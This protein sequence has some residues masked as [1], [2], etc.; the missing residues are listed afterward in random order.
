MLDTF[1]KDY[2]DIAKTELTGNSSYEDVYKHLK[3]YIKEAHIGLCKSIILMISE[4]TKDENT[5][6]GRFEQF[7]CYLLNPGYN[8]HDEYFLYLK[9][10]V[11]FDEQL[12]ID[13]EY[14]ETFCKNFVLTGG[15]DDVDDAD[16]NNWLQNIDKARMSRIIKLFRE[17]PINGAIPDLLKRIDENLQAVSGVPEAVVQEPLRSQVAAHGGERANLVPS[18]ACGLVVTSAAAI[19]S[20][21]KNI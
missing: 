3:I 11:L 4:L 16:H 9:N 10:D 19:V 12:I 20:V 17:D 13:L 18:I 2:A 6:Y 15:Y 1:E 7:I 5:I 14:A 21:L 8:I